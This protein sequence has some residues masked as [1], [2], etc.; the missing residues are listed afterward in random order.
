MGFFD[1]FKTKKFKS[2]IKELSDKIEKFESVMSDEEREAITIK[3]LLEKLKNQQSCQEKTIK[4]LNIEI[5]DKQQKI[6]DLKKQV[7]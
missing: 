2:E 5:S 3:E 7:I 1:V 4:N 6:S